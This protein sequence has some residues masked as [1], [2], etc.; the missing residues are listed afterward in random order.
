MVRISIQ[1]LFWINLGPNLARKLKIFT[2]NLFSPMIKIGKKNFL[3]KKFLKF[4]SNNYFGNVFE[5]KISLIFF[6]KFA[7]MIRIR[8]KILFG[9]TNF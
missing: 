9:K 7:Q 5:K 8:K 3:N 6:R 1:G 2:R 4:F